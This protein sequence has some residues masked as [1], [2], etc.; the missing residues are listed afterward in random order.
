MKKVPQIDHDKNLRLL[1][2]LR[3]WAMEMGA[4]EEVLQDLCKLEDNKEDLNKAFSGNMGRAWKHI[5]KYVKPLEEA[6]NI[7]KTAFLY[8]ANTL[9][10]QIE[11]NTLDES[12]K[13]LPH[14]QDYLLIKEKIDKV[15]KLRR[16]KREVEANVERIKFAIEREAC[17]YEKLA[18][19]VSDTEKK[20]ALLNIISKCTE[21]QV[22]EWNAATD[23]LKRFTFDHKP[24]EPSDKAAKEALVKDWVERCLDVAKKSIDP[25]V[26]EKGE[27][28]ETMYNEFVKDLMVP[29]YEVS[30]KEIMATLEE[31]VAENSKTV[32]KLV[33]ENIP[34]PTFEEFRDVGKLKAD[35]FA[36]YLQNSA[37]VKSLQKAVDKLDAEAMTL[38]TDIMEVLNT[39]LFLNGPIDEDLPS[40]FVEDFIDDRIN[41]RL[42]PK[43]I[44]GMKENITPLLQE[45]ETNALKNDRFEMHCGHKASILKLMRMLQDYL[46][47]QCTRIKGNMHERYKGSLAACKQPEYV[48]L[49]GI[50]F[51][52]VKDVLMDQIELIL[53][54]PM[55]LILSSWKPDEFELLKNEARINLV[56]RSELF[57]GPNHVIIKNIVDA[58]SMN[59]KWTNL[60]LPTMETKILSIDDSIVEDIKQKRDETEKALTD[61]ASYICETLTKTIER[62]EKAETVL[63]DWVELPFYDCIPESLEVDGKTF[64]EWQDSV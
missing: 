38:K 57:N 3:K 64:A 12:V 18:Q 51:E 29:R 19:D 31:I 48:N 47:K 34:D 16:K 25:D 54:T 11:N 63:T 52:D 45:A 10:D 59:Q 43:M 20:T 13:S 44:S 17:S 22:E 56:R 9:Y 15:M 61:K 2:K 40:D 23:A 46:R 37:E 6:D 7:N 41:M 35:G 53:S 39:Y 32:T 50:S 26:Y 5:T 62:T 21:K 27:D 4:P 58:L 30:S 33:E 14:V 49:K 42:L 8:K 24:S 1:K 55:Q 28:T 36:L 60:H